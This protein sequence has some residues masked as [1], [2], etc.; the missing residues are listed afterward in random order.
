MTGHT[1]NKDRAQR[2]GNLSVAARLHDLTAYIREGE[3][4]RMLK[5]DAVLECVEPGV[6]VVGAGPY[7]QGVF[8]LAEATS[9]IRTA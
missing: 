9:H 5:I 8:R 1:D 7:T 6:D 4:P 3:S 2:I